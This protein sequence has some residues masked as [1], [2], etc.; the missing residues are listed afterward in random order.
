MNKKLYSLFA[1]IYL[2][3]VYCAT[4]QGSRNDNGKYYDDEPNMIKKRYQKNYK[5]GNKYMQ[6]T[7]EYD[8][9]NRDEFMH[10][11]NEKEKEMIKGFNRILKIYKACTFGILT[12]FAI[13]IIRLISESVSSSLSNPNSHMSQLIKKVVD[14]KNPNP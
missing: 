11:V 7:D 14:N 3:I 10:L 8:A 13:N 6:R 5:Q 12:I 4:V 2:I 1:F 9:E